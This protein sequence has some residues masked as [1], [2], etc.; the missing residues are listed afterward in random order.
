MN[1]VVYKFRDK[2]NKS[3]E[4]VTKAVCKHCLEKSTFRVIAVETHN[5][6]TGNLEIQNRL[7]CTRCLKSCRYNKKYKPIQHPVIKVTHFTREDYLR[8][9]WLRIKRYFT[10]DHIYGPFKRKRTK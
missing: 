7:A 2:N 8:R 10:G 6:S 1:A 3:Y 4:G 9:T 5:D